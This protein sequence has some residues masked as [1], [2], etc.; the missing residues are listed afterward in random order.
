MSN[1]IKGRLA[2]IEDDEESIQK[3]K[4]IISDLG[5]VLM[6]EARSFHEGF[7][8]APNLKELK[9]T[10]VLLDG[11][12]SPHQHT[13]IEGVLIGRELKKIAPEVRIVGFSSS[14]NQNE[15]DIQMGKS[16]GWEKRLTEILVA[17]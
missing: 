5:W 2:I 8:L 13:G 10:H 12:L 15:V 4:Q 1:E 9:V 6:A 11:N 14:K 16:R 3:V 7:E 17:Q